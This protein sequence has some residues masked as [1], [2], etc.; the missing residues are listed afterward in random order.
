LGCILR[1]TVLQAGRGEHDSEETFSK[2]AYL[3]Q[4]PWL[5]NTTILVNM[6]YPS[7]TESLINEHH[8]TGRYGLPIFHS[9]LGE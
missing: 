1:E 3:P 9:I 6:V 7:S 5:M 2:F 8:Y 4:Y